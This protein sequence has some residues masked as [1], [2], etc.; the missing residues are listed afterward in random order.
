MKY[1]CEI[2]GWIYDEDLGDAEFNIR[3]GTKFEELPKEFKCPECYAGKDAFT[4][5]DE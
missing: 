1:V 2:C 5:T 3:P 4:E